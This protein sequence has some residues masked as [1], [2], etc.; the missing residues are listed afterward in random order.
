MEF[1]P[2]VKGICIAVFLSVINIG[3]ITKHEWWIAMIALNVMIS[4]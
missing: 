4:I 2:I 1:E 3:G